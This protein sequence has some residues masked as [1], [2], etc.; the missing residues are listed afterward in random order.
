MKKLNEKGFA[1]SAIL[2]TM[3]ILIVLL[4]FLIVSLLA[5]RSATLKKMS[6]E[7]KSN[8]DSINNSNSNSNVPLP[9]NSLY[10]QFSTN[11]QTPSSPIV[12][13]PTVTGGIEYPVIDLS[14][15]GKYTI[16][17][18]PPI[19]Y[20]RGAVTDNYVLFHGYCWRM[21]RTTENQGVKVIYNGPSTNGKCE[22]KE[23][24]LILEREKITYANI[25]SVIN[26]FYTNNL[27]AVEDKLENIDVCSESDNAWT[28]VSSGQP[29]IGSCNVQ[30]ES[31]IG[32]LTADEAVYAGAF[33]PGENN[34][35]RVGYYLRIEQTTVYDRDTHGIEYPNINFAT[36]SN[37]KKN[38]TDANGIIYIGG[39]GQIDVG[40]VT[41]AWSK[42]GVRPVIVLKSD[43][44]ITS[45]NGTASNPYV[46]E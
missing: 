13:N 46:V 12:F 42:Y 17:S 21:V 9:E 1:I 5:N 29:S 16:N 11:L 3:L 40:G 14:E 23:W 8:I 31:K 2:Y 44:E 7:V 37:G 10:N 15:K 22:A 27:K 4:M 41:G 45:G 38:A 34:K 30:S 20:Y 43:V 28:R 18:T 39:E 32:L 33:Y 35:L 25:T 6:K 36:M 26:N 24:D 19:Y